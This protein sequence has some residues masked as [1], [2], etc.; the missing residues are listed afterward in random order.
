MSLFGVLLTVSG[1]GFLSWLLFTL[2]TYALPVI[3]GLEIGV[4]AFHSDAGYLGAFIVA[5]AVGSA[6]FALGKFALARARSPF[7]RAAIG[8]LFSVPAALTGYYATL[9]LA[10]IGTPSE[11]WCVVFAVVGA[12]VVGSTAWCRV[13]GFVVS[14]A[15]L[16]GTPRNPG[17]F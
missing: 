7:I 8:L 2:A 14:S 13:T 5:L 6:T 17:S 3:V 12:V 10:R 16:Y 1:L 9:D 15:P 4:V 11:A